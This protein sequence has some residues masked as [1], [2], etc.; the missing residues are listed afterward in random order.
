MSKEF[1]FF[2][3]NSLKKY[4]GKYVA[5]VGRKVVAHGRNAKTVWKT[6]KKKY[7]QSLPTIAKLPKEEV[8]VLSWKT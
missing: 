3:T 6:A 1:D 4:E 7:P 8:L 2:V 5:I